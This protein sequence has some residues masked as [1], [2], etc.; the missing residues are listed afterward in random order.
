MTSV[1][2]GFSTT[3]ALTAGATGS[4]PARAVSAHGDAVNYGSMAG[5]KLNAPSNHIVATPDGRG[6]WLVAAD[7]GTFTFGD[8]WISGSPP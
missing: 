2:A 8:A 4:W 5:Q 1:F 6:Y 7:G 3:T